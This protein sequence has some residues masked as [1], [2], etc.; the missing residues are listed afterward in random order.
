VGVTLPETR[1][2]WSRVTTLM[3]RLLF[4]L[5]AITALVLGY[6]GMGELLAAQDEF[7][8]NLWDRVYYTLQLFVLGAPPLD[9]GGKLPTSLQL[10]R[11]LAPAVTIYA[12][13]EAVRLL[14]ATELTRLRA[15]LSRGHVIVFGESPVAEALTSRLTDD[16]WRVV[17][18]VQ[19]GERAGGWR[20]LLVL[21]GAA[22]RS[23]LLSGAGIHRASTLYV[24]SGDTARDLSIVLTAT[25]LRRR[26]PLRVH[27]QV[28][29]P[30]LCLALQARRLGSHNDDRLIVNF[31]NWHELAAHALLREHRPPV[32]EDRPTRV[33]IVGAS[34]FARA[35][36]VELARSWRL[37]AEPH[38]LEVIV[39]DAA[40]TESVLR[41][42]R[43]Y[44]FAGT[45]CD[46][47][48]RDRDVAT[49]LDGDLADAPPDRVYICCDDEEVGLKLALTM[50]HFWRGGPRSV[51]VRLGQL[52]G[53]TQAFYGSGE[54][55]LDPVSGTLHMFDALRAGTDVNLAEDSLTER[56]ARA[57]HDHYLRRQL[58]S[59]VP[60]G[61]T[62]AMREWP[63]LSD[64]IRAANRA[65]AAD[66]GPKLS[67]IGCALAPNPVWGEPESMT[68]STL[69]H[70]A[71]RE[72]RRWCGFMEEKGWRYGSRR[73][74][75]DLRHPD[76]TR[77]EDLTEEAREKDR[78]AI[79][80][81]PE[82]LAD[83]GFRIVRVRAS[84]PAIPQ[85]RRAGDDQDL[86]NLPG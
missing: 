26:T 41:L 42:Q 79:R 61:A 52:G 32:H 73:S 58:A 31:F 49:L 17:R 65:Q 24:C 48:T 83:A 33:M 56:L 69:E 50:D 29:D 9:E 30:E 60:L 66:I 6:S 38:R 4:P 64:K 62:A 47:L 55:L 28:D 44:P 70:L 43:L 18:L 7:A 53:L 5:M 40:A 20:R 71:R 21:P 15:R 75:E 1:G 63:E 14:F 74:E 37:H 57:I 34:W 12:V 35:L 85:P 27:V 46:F 78:D 86:T 19:P 84:S 8:D 3:W 11:F 39:V 10:A 76:L 59:G 77:W 82:L 2:G 51:I 45:V 13:M 23:G 16:G 81:L 80:Q 36:I 54:G 22:S 72:H 67:A 68:A 25:G